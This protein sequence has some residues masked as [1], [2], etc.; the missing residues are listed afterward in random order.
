M[1]QQRDG[2][3]Q[4]AGMSSQASREDDEL[5]SNKAVRGS[6]DPD[7]DDGGSVPAQSRPSEPPRLQRPM[8]RR[9]LRDLEAAR[10][11]RLDAAPGAQPISS[12]S[13]S[14]FMGLAPAPLPSVMLPSKKRS[15]DE[16]LS[17]DSPPQK[18]KMSVEIDQL[19]GGPRGSSLNHAGPS[20]T[21]DAAHTPS[22]PPKKS[23]VGRGPL[24]P[25]PSPVV[26]GDLATSPDTPRN[27]PPERRLDLPRNPSRA[28]SRERS[29]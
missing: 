7:S 15:L 26:I 1:S 10:T 24:S 2:R 11:K 29:S 23:R 19:A 25:R 6:S 21:Q 28:G 13:S 4:D 20:A 3:F 27:R 14:S 16:V 8:T 9:F 17:D 18:D 12:S 5:W 22:R